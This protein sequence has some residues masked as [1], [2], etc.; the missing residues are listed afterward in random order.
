MSKITGK[1]KRFDGTNVDYVLIFDWATGKQLDVVIPNTSGAWSYSYYRDIKVGFLYI[2][3][4]CEPIAHGA[5]EFLGINDSL[6]T[7][8]DFSDGL[9]GWVNNN[10]YWE[11]TD[12]NAYHPYTSSYQDLVQ[13]INYVGNVVITID[14][15]V[16]RGAAELFVI[17]EKEVVVGVGTHRVVISAYSNNS[18]VGFSRSSPIPSEFY[19]SKITVEKA[20]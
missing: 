9:N 3:D 18:V 15:V 14:V 5:Y 1:A 11:W 10:S 6:I 7:N 19:V 16:I 13:S 12:G 17:G 20:D 2:A 4:G 8:G